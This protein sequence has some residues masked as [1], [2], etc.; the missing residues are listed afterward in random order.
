MSV[1]GVAALTMKKVEIQ[2]FAQC[3][4]AKLVRNRAP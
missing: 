3:S 1:P 4:P 2:K